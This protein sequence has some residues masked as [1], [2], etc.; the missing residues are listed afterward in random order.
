MRGGRS[1]VVVVLMA[2]LA[3]PVPAATPMPPAPRPSPTPAD[4]PA[5]PKASYTWREVPG[6]RLEPPASTERLPHLGSRVFTIDG[7]LTRV[8]VSVLT[9]APGLHAG[10]VAR[11]HC[12]LSGVVSYDTWLPAHLGP[13]TAL[14]AGAAG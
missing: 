7:Q 5:T 4:T 3:G 9:L 14:G 12:G 8:A 6:W 2:S 11:P 1:L 13:W 10:S